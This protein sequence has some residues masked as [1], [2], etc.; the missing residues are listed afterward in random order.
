MTIATS[1]SG[2]EISTR[3]CGLLASK[4]EGETILHKF[5]VGFRFGIVGGILGLCA[6][7]HF[8]KSLHSRMIILMQVLHSNSPGTN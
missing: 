4:K 1:S 3:I 5:S 7:L 2:M 8:I 6:Q